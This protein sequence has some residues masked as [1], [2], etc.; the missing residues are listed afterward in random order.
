[1]SSAY[2]L[3]AEG[4]K[5]KKTNEEM[6]KKA[7]D[8]SKM[9]GAGTSSYIQDPISAFLILVIVTSATRDIWFPLLFKN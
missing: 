7:V 4:D 5:I 3:W 6:E 9:E 1:M 8:L 2:L